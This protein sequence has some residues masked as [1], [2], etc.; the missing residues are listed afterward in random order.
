MIRLANNRDYIKMYSILNELNISYIPAEKV[1]N[2]IANKE[3]YVIEEEG[4]IKAI[5]SLVKCPSY[6][7]YAIKRMCVFEEGKG[8]AN[9]LINFLIKKRAN[10]PIVCTPWED[11][12]IMRHILERNHF[13]LKYIFNYKWCLYEL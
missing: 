8:Y 3:C 4:R 13:R 5:C 9:Q 12:S 2:D 1:F 7:N 11:N 10:L 6:H